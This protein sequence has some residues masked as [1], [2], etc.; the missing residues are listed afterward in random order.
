MRIEPGRSPVVALACASGLGLNLHVVIVEAQVR[1]I[2]GRSELGHRSR[3]TRPSSETMAERN[4]SQL[5]S[6]MG[7]MDR[8]S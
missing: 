3:F 4:S 2:G 5:P 7:R 6:R 8:G 1:K